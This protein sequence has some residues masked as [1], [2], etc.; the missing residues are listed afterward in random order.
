MGSSGGRF[1]IRFAQSRRDA[2]RACS[3]VQQQQRFEEPGAPLHSLNVSVPLRPAPPSHQSLC[4]VAE[5]T[6]PD[7]T[8]QSRNA[9][10]LS[11]PSPRCQPV[12]PG[13]DDI[14]FYNSVKG[15]EAAAGARCLGVRRRWPRKKIRC[16]D[17]RRRV[18][19][20]CAT[21]RMSWERQTSPEQESGSMENIGGFFDVCVVGLIQTPP[22][23]RA[24]LGGNPGLRD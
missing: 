22:A 23:G 17:S 14:S 5:A 3:V 20:L 2:R 13:R 21:G 1:R 19:S 15:P 11:Q 8:G 24:S 18:P 16:E 6:G 12:A 7:E 9:N 10:Q 4:L